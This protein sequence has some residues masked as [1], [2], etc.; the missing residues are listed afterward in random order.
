MPKICQYLIHQRC[1]PKATVNYLIRRGIL[2]ADDKGNAVFLLLGKEK[3][4]V[5]AEIRGTNDNL[6]KWRG[7]APGSKKNLGCFYIRTRGANKVVLCESAIDA[8]S[9]FVLHSNCM[10]MSTAGVNSVPPWLENLIEKG[11]EI[12]CAFDSDAT[13]ELMANKMIKLYPL[14][15]RLRP[16]KH[17]WNE[18]LQLMVRQTVDSDSENIGF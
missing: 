6:R 18:V 10:A 4:V 11:F 15:K 13:G 1:L 7:M 8:I 9:Y 3:R 2:Y 12:F 17:D 16:E 5:G 14:V